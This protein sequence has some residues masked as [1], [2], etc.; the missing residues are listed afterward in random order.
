MPESESPSEFSDE[1][2]KSIPIQG[3][4]LRQVE[5]DP[6]VMAPIQYLQHWGE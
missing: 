5:A 2:S 3:G 4:F 1:D 6:L